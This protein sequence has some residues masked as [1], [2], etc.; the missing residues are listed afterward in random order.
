MI[1]E[2]ESFIVWGHSRCFR[3]AKLKEIIKG[4]SD[5]A[6]LNINVC[7]NVDNGYIHALIQIKRCIYSFW[8]GKWYS[9][10]L[11]YTNSLGHQ[12]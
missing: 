1:V 7:I 4:E 3:V 10:F 11:S 2:T 8:Y 6:M 12:S 5:S 9:G